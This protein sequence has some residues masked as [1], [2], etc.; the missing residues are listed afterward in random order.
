MKSFKYF[1]FLYVVF[2]FEYFLFC[3]YGR[4]DLDP[5]MI[6]LVGG[7][8]RILDPDLEVA[9]LAGGHVAAVGTV[10][11]PTIVRP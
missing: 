7:W 3:S 11:T 2:F 4:F 1:F 5:A 10:P 6:Q 8:I 9:L